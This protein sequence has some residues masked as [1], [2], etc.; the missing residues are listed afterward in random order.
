MR[1]RLAWV[2]LCVAAAAVA[3][4]ALE[5]ELSYSLPPGSVLGVQM[6]YGSLRIV[7]GEH[8]DVRVRIHVDG[9]PAM[10]AVAMKRL[11]VRFLP[12][13]REM[14]LEIAGLNHPRVEVAVPSHVHLSAYLRAGDMSIQNIKGDLNARMWAGELNVQVPEQSFYRSVRASVRVGSVQHPF[15]STTHGWLGQKYEKGSSQGSYRLNASVGVGDLYISAPRQ[16]AM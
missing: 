15:G 5:K 13:G 11:N 14:R 16:R 4:P 10:A 6:K 8:S 12:V 1:R 3:A 7:G 2:L 9:Q